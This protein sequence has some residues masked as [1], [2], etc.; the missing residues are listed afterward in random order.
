[1]D[2]RSLAG[3]IGRL[4][5]LRTAVIGVRPEINLK[6]LVLRPDTT[7]S[8]AQKETRPVY[9]DDRFVD[10]PLYE[11]AALPWDA[12]IA[13]PAVIE[14]ADTTIWLEPGVAARVQ[15]GGNLLVEIS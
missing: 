3:A 5:N 2:D 7:L 1:M 6:D 11:R 8:Q 9:I 4:V 10:C 15:E 14:Q 13:G 12:R